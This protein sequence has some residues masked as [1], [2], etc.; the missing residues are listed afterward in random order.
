[1][2]TTALDSEDLVALV[3]A[4]VEPKK[5]AALL[6]TSRTFHAVGRPMLRASVFFNASRMLSSFAL[7]E[8][9]HVPTRV[10]ILRDGTR[11]V[12]QSP[13]DGN[14]RLE[15]F[16]TSNV[17]HV[18]HVQQNRAIAGFAEATAEAE[19]GIVAVVINRDAGDDPNE[20]PLEYGAE[21]HVWDKN[22]SH[23]STVLP[24]GHSEFIC[25]ED[26][27]SLSTTATPTIFK[28]RATH[29]ERSSGSGGGCY[30]RTLVHNPSL[31]TEKTALLAAF[32]LSSGE[33]LPSRCRL[34]SWNDGD[35]ENLRPPQ[36]ATAVAASTDMPA[37]DDRHRFG[38]VAC[39]A[40]TSDDSGVV[41][42]TG[43]L[44]DAD[45][46]VRV[47]LWDARTGAVL[48]T[49]EGP[50]LPTKGFSTAGVTRVT[51][52]DLFVCFASVDGTLRLFRRTAS[53]GAQVYKSTEA[54]A[55]LS[56]AGVISPDATSESGGGSSRGHTN[57]VESIAL[58]S[59]FLVA[60]FTSG[61]RYARK[62]QVALFRLD[63]TSDTQ[64]PVI[65]CGLFPLQEV[66]KDHKGMI[67]I[68]SIGSNLDQS[69]KVVLACSYTKDDDSDAAPVG[70]TLTFDFL[71]AA[72]S[73]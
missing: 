56:P 57:K 69:G 6:P 48:D 7:M 64:H 70:L 36:S 45:G 12:L 46:I 42:A 53:R 13:L 19:G 17:K 21:L 27:L 40:F 38:G 52:S 68:N 41:I 73:T 59:N 30:L 22:E 10:D 67:K 23:P 33:L 72:A 11:A 9:T 2:P 24:L 51:V 34:L 71:V 54:V 61:T 50:Q 32:S 5:L 26:P 35:E 44:R 8:H 20:A 63:S 1:M 15:I 14:G 60:A 39:A 66:L 49:F 4:C 28:S 58:E 29:I 65:M 16:G 47:R 31:A 25:G 55:I 43:H 62:T 18:K 3:L 37:I